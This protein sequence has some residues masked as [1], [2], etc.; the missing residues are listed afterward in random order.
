LASGLAAVASKT[1]PISAKVQPYN[2]PNAWMPLLESGEIEMGIINILD[3]SMAATGTGEY[4]KPY[5]AIRVVSGGVFPF[6]AGLI[7]RDKSDIKQITDLKGQA[8]GMGLRR[9]RHQ[10]DVAKRRHGNRGAQ[11]DRRGASTSFQS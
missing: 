1:T 9:A 10:P 4:K 5:P 6:T 11:G 7:V 8:V 2:G 3:S